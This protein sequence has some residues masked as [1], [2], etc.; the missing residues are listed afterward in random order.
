VRD[1]PV[2][3]SRLSIPGLHPLSVGDKVYG[4]V[5]ALVA[6]IGED[7]VV[8]VGEMDVEGFDELTGDLMYALQSGQTAAPEVYVRIAGILVKALLTLRA[9]GTWRH[10]RGKA[11]GDVELV[12]EEVSDELE[13]RWR[14]RA[15]VAE[16]ALTAKE[17]P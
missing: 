15:S 6:V 8:L 7:R 14:F 17:T 12:V 2:R 10:S 4:N 9:V 13:E 1:L 3:S 5:E 16:K 11:V